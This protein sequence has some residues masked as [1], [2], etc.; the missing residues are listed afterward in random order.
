[1]HKYHAALVTTAEWHQWRIVYCGGYPLPDV[2]A[3]PQLLY[4]SNNIFQAAGLSAHD[5]AWYSNSRVC[6]CG[7]CH[8][9]IHNSKFVFCCFF[10]QSDLRPLQVI[11]VELLGQRTLI[12]YRRHDHLPYRPHQYVLL[13]GKVTM[14]TTK[15]N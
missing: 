4:Y 15:L 9:N 13:P 2:S 12:L 10:D 1:M 8:S 7:P 5:A 11:L 6:R 3:Y 14:D